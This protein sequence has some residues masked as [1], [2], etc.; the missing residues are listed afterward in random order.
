MSL[1][2]RKPDF[3]ICENKDADQLRSNT[4]QLISAFVFAIR[5]VRSLFYLN[6]K[7]QA[8]SY[9]LW[10]YSL[11]CVG[12]PEDRFSH[13]EAH[14]VLSVSVPDIVY[15]FFLTKATRMTTL[16]VFI[17]FFTDIFC[18]SFL[19]LAKSMII[20][21]SIAGK[22]ICDKPFNAIQFHFDWTIMTGHNFPG[23]ER[24]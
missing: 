23:S 15:P 3:C 16:N 9:I 8:S 12:N 2:M 5:I 1:V 20:T 6:P 14:M 24:D 4:A 18:F 7:F 22:M 19:C 10:L 21:A 13:N 17:K 11:V